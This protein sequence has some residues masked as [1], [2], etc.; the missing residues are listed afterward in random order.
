MGY[1]LTTTLEILLSINTSFMKIIAP[2]VLLFASVL[3]LYAQPNVALEAFATGLTEPVDIAHAGDERLF[4]VERP[5]LIRIVEPDGD[6]LPAPFLDITADV[7]DNA[8]ERGLLG[9]AFHPDY[10]D[11]GYFF[12]NYTGAAGATHVS[13]FQ[14]SAGNPNLADPTSEVVL[15]TVSQPFSNHNGGDLNFGP[16]G[17]LYIG[18]GDGGSFNDPGNNSQTTTTMLGKMLRID[19]DNP[20]GGLDYGIPPDNPFLTPDDGILDEIWA[21]GLR[22]PWRFSFDRQTGDLW[23][24]DVGQ[25]Q[26]EE[27][28]F[29]PAGSPGGEN[30]GW[31]CREGAHDYLTA[32]CDPDAVF[33]DPVWEYAHTGA[34]GCS[35]TGGYMYR[36]CQYPELYGYY[37]CADYCTGRFW[38]IRDDGAGNW[39]TVDLANLSNFEF[40]SFGEDFN[41][42][43]YV[44]AIGSGQVLRVVETT[45]SMD[46]EVGATDESCEGAGNGT[47]AAS[48]MEGINEPVTI[49]WSTGS[50][51]LF[52][53]DLSAGNY[54]LTITGG[55]G[56]T[57]QADLEVASGSP[58]PP[59]IEPLGDGLS[60]PVNFVSYQ[61]YVD[62]ELIE[63]ADMPLYL[64]DVEGNYTV[65]V[66]DGNGCELTSAP[67][68]FMTNA[69][70]SI[71]GLQAWTVAPNP[72][73]EEIVLSLELD[74]PIQGTLLL[75]DRLGRTLLSRP[76]TAVGRH[77]EQLSLQDLPAGLYFLHLQTP[78][79]SA[80]L[81]I[82]RE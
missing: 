19:V 55:N 61:W 75:T 63:G 49:E 56:C 10:A 28:D 14:V 7:V 18:L 76:I 40:V 16:D 2:L 27:V 74:E 57:F 31:K 53:A 69:V 59:T 26:Y 22:N 29:Q 23:I 35:I 41:G 25:D 58:T 43:L 20:S 4:V 62:G 52:L 71:A 24:G 6:V 68:F 11:N 51:D 77:Q 73:S 48:W 32:N 66:V 30:Y 15:F 79:G 60:V 34:N 42:E 37:L 54:G 70:S 47:A 5:G 21:T 13:R 72:F 8:S 46:I 65:V 9:L 50:T 39:E 3:C 67:F 1:S 45:A 17:Y 64:P 81:R 12:V 82:V 33:V 36:G 80:V 78:Q 44:A 38:G